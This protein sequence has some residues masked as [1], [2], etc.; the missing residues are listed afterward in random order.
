MNDVA[1][2]ALALRRRIEQR[3]HAH[4]PTCDVVD[5][6][7]RAR[8]LDEAAVH[9]A[10][11]D[12]AVVH[13]E[14]DVGEMPDAELAPFAAALAQRVH[15]LADAR[16]LEPVPEP[17]RHVKWP[18]LSGAA[19]AVAAIAIAALWPSL[20]THS[21]TERLRSDLE[22]AQ[23]SV[24]SEPTS[25]RAVERQPAPRQKPRSQTTEIETPEIETPVDAPPD[26]AAPRR[27]RTGLDEVEARAHAKWKAGNLADAE[28]A[29]REVIRRSGRTRRAELAFADL[30]AVAHQRGGEPAQ[31]R[32]W[33]A[34]LSR[35][36]NGRFADDVR[37]GLC[38]RADATRRSACWTTYLEHHPH[39]AHAGQARK[40]VATQP[41]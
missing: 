24:E 36:P 32:V 35:F 8:A 27:E 10:L 30:F 20:D 15:S 39:G 12:S 40:A 33:R 1:T 38:R 18:W 16:R 4:A 9:E 28:A 5:V 6:I 14:D 13:A 25:G 19:M 34:Y 17:R 2:F 37:G 26:G 31:S 11:R 22:A 3:V 21:I 41:R 29:L 7:D 23:R